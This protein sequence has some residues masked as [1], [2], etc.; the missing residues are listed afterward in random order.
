MV[1]VHL[2]VE[3]H[4]TMI[5]KLTSSKYIDN[6]YANVYVTTP[7]LQVKQMSHCIRFASQPRKK[8]ICHVTVARTLRYITH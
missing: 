5:K 4:M 1:D 8:N 6:N 7:T 2:D 3:A